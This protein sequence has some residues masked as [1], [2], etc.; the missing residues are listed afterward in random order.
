VT[1]INFTPLAGKP[2]PQDLREQTAPG[3]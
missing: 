1:W 3:K 2:A